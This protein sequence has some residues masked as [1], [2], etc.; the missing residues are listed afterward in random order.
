MFISRRAIP[1]VRD[2]ERTYPQIHIFT[3]SVQEGASEQE[4]KKIR[5]GIVDYSN[6]NNIDQS[7]KTLPEILEQITLFRKQIV[8]VA[9][10]LARIESKI[11]AVTNINTRVLLH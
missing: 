7:N 11:D 3:R 8:M 1:R 4:M 10:Q 6:D 5:N 9:Q 2:T